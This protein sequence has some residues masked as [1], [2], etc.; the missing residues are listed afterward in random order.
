MS[1]TDSPVRLIEKSAGAYAFAPLPGPRKQLWRK[2]GGV[3][4]LEQSG[5]PPAAAIAANVDARSCS[6]LLSLV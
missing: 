4:S 3:A 1:T 6:T 5:H 2:Q